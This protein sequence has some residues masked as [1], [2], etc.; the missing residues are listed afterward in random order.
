MDA[1][2]LRSV[3]E[4]QPHD[5]SDNAYAFTDDPLGGSPPVDGACECLMDQLPR[6][7]SHSC[8]RVGELA[9]LCLGSDGSERLW[10]NHTCLPIPVTIEGSVV[11]LEYYTRGCTI[12]DDGELVLR[13]EN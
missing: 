8:A 9:H 11:S 12:P 3:Q 7:R 6:E 5:D 1:L 13:Q 2:H 10:Q 4:S